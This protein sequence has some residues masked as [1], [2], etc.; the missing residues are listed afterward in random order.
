MSECVCSERVGAC[1]QVAREFAH[2]VRVM[3]VRIAKRVY[4]REKVVKMKK[5]TNFCI[6]FQKDLVNSKKSST[7]ARFFVR[8]DYSDVAQRS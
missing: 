3:C 5:L 1:A 8:T 7:F 4:A 6:F 2:G